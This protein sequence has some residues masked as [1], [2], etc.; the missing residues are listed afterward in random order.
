MLGDGMG[1]EDSL[2]LVLTIG[3]AGCS[4]FVGFIVAVEAWRRWS[5]NR[6]IR[7][8]LHN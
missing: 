6:E 2:L 5:Y 8:H 3:L 7:K 1:W 4:L